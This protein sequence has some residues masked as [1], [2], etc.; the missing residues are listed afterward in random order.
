MDIAAPVPSIEAVYER[1]SVA[2]SELF[3]RVCTRLAADPRFPSFSEATQSAITACDCASEEAQSLIRPLFT[4][5]E[6]ELRKQINQLN[7]RLLFLPAAAG[8]DPQSMF[9]NAEQQDF[10]AEQAQAEGA[11]EAALALESSLDAFLAD[12]DTIAAALEAAID[13]GDA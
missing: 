6:L 9:L 7:N 10:L 3:L 12:D 11:Q 5:K 4:L 1:V 2:S 8:A 13:F